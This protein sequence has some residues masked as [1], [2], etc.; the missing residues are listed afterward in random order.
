[1]QYKCAL[2]LAVTALSS[3]FLLMYSSIINLKYTMDHYQPK[4]S[5]FSFRMCMDYLMLTCFGILT[6][7]IPMQLLDIL[8]VF[9][10]TM[11]SLI[12]CCSK[13][14]VDYV[15]NAFDKVTERITSLTNYQ[16][17]NIKYASGISRLLN[18]NVLWLL[19]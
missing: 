9:V 5:K 3:S 1:M 11:T 15:S 19:L 17:Q 7:V 16:V 14:A 4:D 10:L 2:L 13:K 12:T 6:T 8:Q 18:E